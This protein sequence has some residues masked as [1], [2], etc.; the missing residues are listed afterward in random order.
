MQ[1]PEKLIDLYRQKGMR[2]TPQRR[3]IFEILSGDGSHPTVDELYQSV[4]SHM[5][6]VS[7]STVYNTVNE[8]VALGELEIV[9]NTREGGTRYDPETSPH[10][11]MYCRSCQKLIDLL[12]DDEPL[13]LAPENVSGFKVERIQVTFYGICPDCQ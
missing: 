4:R 7:R 2:I 13:T 1:S 6:E 8:L 12:H 5:P 9:E 11:H 3:L 10:H